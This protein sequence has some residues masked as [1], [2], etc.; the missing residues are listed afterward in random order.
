MMKVYKKVKPM[1]SRM[2][3]LTSF[4]LALFLWGVSYDVSAQCIYTTT[5][6]SGT[7]SSTSSPAVTFGAFA[8]AGEFVPTTFNDDGIY[9][10]GSTIATDFITV[11]DASNNVID[12][13]LQPLTVSI[14]TT[15]LYRIHIASNSSCGTGS[16]GRSL[17]GEYIGP[18]GGGSISVQ[19]G[20]GTSIPTW[21]LNFPIYRFNATSGS[22]SN[23]SFAIYEESELIAAGIMPGS[24]IE[25]IGFEKSAGGTIN[26]VEL[27][28]YMRTGTSTPPLA[29]ATWASVTA[30]ASLVYDDDL[31]FSA[32]DN[33]VDIT[34][35]T[36]FVYTGG[37]LEIASENFT[38]GPSP[39]STDGFK[40]IYDNTFGT[41]HEI[42]RTGFGS[43]S[44]L[45]LF[46][47]TT[48][49]FRPN[50]RFEV[51]APDGTDLAM[52]G[53]VAPLAACPGSTDVIVAILNAGSE[54][55][56]T[57]TIGWTLNGVAQTSVTWTGNIGTGDTAHVNLGSFTSAASTLYNIEAYI[58]NVGPGLDTNTSNDTIGTAY[59][60]ALDGNFT[61]NAGAPAS[62]TNFQTFD[63]A[64][65]ALN[66]FGV[67][68]PVL[69]EA[70]ADTFNEQVI[71]GDVAGA[72]ATNTI[73]FRGAGAGNTVLT[74]A[75]NVS[76]DRYTFRLNGASYVTIDSMSIV[77]DASGTYGWS[78]HLTN[79]AHDITITNCSIVTS[80]SSTSSFYNGLIASGSNTSWSLQSTGHENITISNNIF[81]G[82]YYNIRLNGNI[83]DKMTNV[84]VD[85]NML[86]D[87][88]NTG[89]YLFYVDGIEV[90]SNYLEARSG[91]TFGQGIWISDSQDY[92]IN[93]NEIYKQG[94]Y[95]IYISNAGGTIASPVQVS[96]NAISEVGST[97]IFASAI[98]ILGN[99]SFIDIVNNSC[100][101]NSGAG[102]VFQITVTTPSNLRLLNNT[103]VH[104]ESDGYAMYILNGSVFAQ[105]DNNNYF[106]PGNNFVYY[107][108]SNRAD[109]AALQAQNNPTGNDANSVEADPLYIAAD[110]LVPLNGALSGAGVAFAGVT[111]DITGATRATPPDIGAYEFVPVNAD[112]ALIAGELV[113]GECLSTNDTVVLHIVNTLGSTINLAVDSIV[114]HFD[115]T[116]PA[117][118]NG[119]VVFNSGNLPEGDT[120]MAFATGVDLSIT[121]IY[122]LNAYIDTNAV[123]ESPA[124]DTLGVVSH[125]IRP[126]FSVSPT[127]VTVTNNQDSVEVTARSPFMPGGDFFI[128]EISH[129][130]GSSTGAPS[131]G[132]PSYLIADD[133]IEITGVPSSDLGGVTLEVW[134]TTTQ[135]TNYTFPPGTMMSPNGTAIVAT[136]QL[137]ASQP[138]PANFYY[139]GNGAFTGSYF[140]GAAIGYI[141]KDAGG[142]IIDAC[143]FSGTTPYVFPAAANVSTADWSGS[144]PS[145]SGTAGSRLEG[146]YTKDATN[147]L[148]S[149]ATN[150]Q[151]PNSVNPSVSVPVSGSV[152]G[153][154][155]SFGGTLI[156][157]VPSVFVGPFATPGTYYA[158]ATY[159]TPCGPQTDSVEILVD[160][161]FCFEPDSVEVIAACEDAE[162]SWVSGSFATH[163]TSVEYGPAGFTQGSGVMLS[164]VNSP[165][166]LDSLLPSTDYDYYIYDSCTTTE[167]AWT[168]DNTLPVSITSDFTFSPTTTTLSSCA[169]TLE[170]VVPSG[171]TISSVDV[172]YDVAAGLGGWMNEQRNYIRCVSPGGVAESSI[173]SGVGTGGTFN[174]NRTGL[175][176][177]N[178]V[179][180]T[181]T[182]VFE[183]HNF[184]T[185]GGTGCAAGYNDVVP[186][187]FKV[188][189]HHDTISNTFGIGEST[190]PGSF[191]TEDLPNAGNINFTHDGSGGYTFTSDSTARGSLTWDFGDG[192]TASGDTVFNQYA[193]EGPYMVTVVATNV[194]GSDTATASIA[195]ISVDAY[196]LDNIAIYPN[197]SRG[198][199]VIDQLPL[200]GGQM[201]MMIHDMAGQAVYTKVHAA[202]IQRLELGLDHLS[203]GTYFIT[204]SNDYGRTTKSVVIVK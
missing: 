105:I 138:S 26:D 168:A 14:P 134:N 65:D 165:V 170:V 137:G 184:R 80:T 69:F 53:F 98:R 163:I 139:H 3:G 66:T 6:S 130:R 91:T 201:T 40:W 143:A 64:I 94:Q 63:D 157:T 58:Q 156:D 106:S 4:V 145:G 87:A 27:K 122:T 120:A 119:T 193:A 181:D 67:C 180:G 175:T 39:Y 82:G 142:N 49:S 52:Q 36:P 44:T 81:V 15:G 151:D 61:I 115:V 47:S 30:G 25:G 8:W 12:F 38:P 16:P 17:T 131:G 54:D 196:S 125:E 127:S 13:G 117:T 195:Y 90:Q 203:A 136:A 86:L 7:L 79:E 177:A 84:V 18:L 124:N 166:T 167:S 174:Y 158:V 33:W 83:T 100:L 118:S 68:G 192:N 159:Q 182:I 88:S 110:N 29:N 51:I 171:V 89:L 9:E 176:I 187:S 108:G 189:I 160:F 45:D 190:T 5:W 144:V 43:F 188:T 186:G 129:W 48:Y 62:G 41:S 72:S 73:T 172:E 126:V 191:R 93:A 34:F 153:L 111:T 92:L 152:T 178:G 31:S 149:S 78:V 204:L 162:L 71:L 116:G 50:T 113:N 20:F 179:T 109:L 103:F 155:W 75:Q 60:A 150:P 148:V 161:P 21:T 99:S 112:V 198:D 22:N 28:L 114:A 147:W 85:N 11:T 135:N 46:S 35:S 146:A 23:R 74:F 194:C 70:V 10:I 42:G 76:D 96:N 140:S 200:D 202:G 102:R 169:G 199:V 123:N 173:S 56:D 185:W 97:S 101:L 55:V 183:L 77:S 1:T 2:S 133:Y 141:L 121:G 104:T 57:A 197:P 132:W 19:I 107:D 24:T 37:T 154:E 59:Q 95:G 128:T 164:N 32:T